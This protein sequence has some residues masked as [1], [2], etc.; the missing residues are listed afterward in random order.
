MREGPLTKAQRKWTCRAQGPLLLAA[1]CFRLPTPATRAQGRGSESRCKVAPSSAP[2]AMSAWIGW[3]RGRAC[4]RLLPR[5]VRKRG[6]AP[7]TT[8]STCRHSPRT[9]IS[10][11]RYSFIHALNRIYSWGG[12]SRGESPAAG[13]VLMDGV[14][15][16][17]ASPLGK[18]GR[19]GQGQKGPKTKRKRP[20]ATD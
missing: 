5:S 7:P 8:S 3:R 6:R 19:S 1:G 4:R 18:D 20:N 11:F 2:P 17:S 15:N 12:R 13:L 14:G 10:A 9:H 16:E